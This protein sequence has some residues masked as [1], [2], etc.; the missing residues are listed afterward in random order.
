MCAT[1]AYSL[2]AIRLL[3]GI[4]EAGFLPGVL[5]YLTYWF[6]RTWSA[7]ATG[8]F[9]IAQPVTIACGSTLSGVILQIGLAGRTIEPM[10]LRRIRTDL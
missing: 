3:V 9:M 7:R 5:L 2:Y 1:D 6:P 10:I 4:A 8:A